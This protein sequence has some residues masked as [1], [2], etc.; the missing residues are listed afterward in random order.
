MF[1]VHVQ[2]ICET[3]SFNFTNASANTFTVPLKQEPGEVCVYI[4]EGNHRNMQQEPVLNCS[5]L[6]SSHA[7][8]QYQAQ[9]VTYNCTSNL[10]MVC[11]N[12]YDRPDKG[13]GFTK[14][15]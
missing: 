15:I 12:A 10:G 6:T 13:G 14:V 2:S 4:W 7:H 5:K 3:S 11:R 1:A 8:S 9:Q